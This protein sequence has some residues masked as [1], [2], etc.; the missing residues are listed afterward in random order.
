VEAAREGMKLVLTGIEDCAHRA[1]A[2]ELIRYGAEVV[3]ATTDV[4]APEGGQS[5]IDTAVTAYGGLDILVDNAGIGAHGRF[6]DLTPE[7]L[8]QVMEVNFFSCEETRRHRC[9]LAVTSH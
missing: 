7:S 8:R 5:M 1:T 4:T 2:D 9:S 3:A 6:L